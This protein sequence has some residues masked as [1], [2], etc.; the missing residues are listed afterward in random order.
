MNVVDEIQ[1]VTFRL[2][3]HEFAFNV[4]DVERILK[5]EDPTPVPKAPPYLLGTLQYGEEVI[6][7]IDLRERLDLEASVDEATRIVI[8]GW[9]D[10]KVGLVVD[11]VLEVLKTAAASVR[12]PPSMVRG[13]AAECINGILTLGERT[14]ILLAVQKL[15]ASGERLA[16]R[17][18]M[19]E[20][21]HE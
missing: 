7:L 20:L 4:F 17:G 2:G 19:A 16:L 11:A 13:L 1:L 15:L 9:E 21:T 14:V 5:Y 18:L 12:Q 3:G 8:V 10:G 6:P